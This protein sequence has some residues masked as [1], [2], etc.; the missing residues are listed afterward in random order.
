MKAD[1]VTVAGVFGDADHDFDGELVFEENDD[2]W[3]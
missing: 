1:A 2:G 3:R